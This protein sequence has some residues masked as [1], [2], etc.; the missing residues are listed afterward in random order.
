[1]EIQDENEPLIE[2]YKNDQIIIINELSS[3]QIKEFQ[4]KIKKL[5]SIT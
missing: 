1:M 2:D 5:I 3:D 4:N